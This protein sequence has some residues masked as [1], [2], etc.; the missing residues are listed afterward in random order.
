MV[1]KILGHL[2]PSIT[3]GIYAHASLDMQDQAAN[4]MEEI[5][6]PISISLSNILEIDH[7]EQTAKVGV[8]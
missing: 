7:G 6:S 3:L 1:S 8:H 2:S 5:V 4:V